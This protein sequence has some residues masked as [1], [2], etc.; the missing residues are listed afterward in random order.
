LDDGAI[1]LL[2][3]IGHHFNFLMAPA[4]AFERQ[5][6]VTDFAVAFEVLE[7]FLA[8]GAILEQTD[9]KQ[10]LADQLVTRIAQQLGHERIGI[11]DLAGVRVEHQ[12]AVM[13][14][15]KQAAV[16]GF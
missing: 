3:E 2:I 4:L 7:H 11:G 5:V 8:R 13:G 9:L 16:A 12:D 1:I 6:L 14:G 15:F 10:F